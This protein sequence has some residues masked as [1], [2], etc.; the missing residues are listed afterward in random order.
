MTL[1]HPTCVSSGLLPDLVEPI[2]VSLPFL[3][4][5]LQQNLVPQLSVVEDIDAITALSSERETNSEPFL[6]HKPPNAPIVKKD[7]PATWPS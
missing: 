7:A 1:T 4:L 6:V 5:R 3:D 2:L